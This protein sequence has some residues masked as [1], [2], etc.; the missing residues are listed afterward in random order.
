MKV[1]NHIKLERKKKPVAGE[2]YA[3]GLVGR[4][5]LKPRQLWPASNLAG[6]D[7]SPQ[8]PFLMPQNLFFDLKL[9]PKDERWKVNSLGILSP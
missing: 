1:N 2:T 6:C 9:K 8:N 3:V 4:E 5:Y 7:P